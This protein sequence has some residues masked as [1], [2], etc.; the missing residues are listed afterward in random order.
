DNRCRSLNHHR[1]KLVSTNIK[2]TS[3]LNQPYLN[4]FSVSFNINKNSKKLGKMAEMAEELMSPETCAL[5]VDIRS[6]INSI[7]YLKFHNDYM[8]ALNPIDELEPLED[9]DA[10]KTF[11]EI[12][13]ITFDEMI[14]AKNAQVYWDTVVK[15]RVIDEPCNTGFVVE[16]ALVDTQYT[17]CRSMFAGLFDADDI[18][19]KFGF[20][21]EM[22]IINPYF[23]GQ[24]VSASRIENV[25]F[26]KRNVNRCRVC[27]L[28][29][30]LASAWKSCRGC[31]ARYCSDKC[32][33]FD[34]ENMR[35]YLICKSI[36]N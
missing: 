13:P 27:A 26:L 33:K 23:N 8:S 6:R 4:H 1:N 19:V 15:C 17:V 28:E 34:V 29:F 35:H 21:R 2:V 12:K 25:V 22:A 30:L 10:P 20:G 5:I 36:I 11:M 18:N 9:K 32:W 16:V 31:K 7:K 24:Y 14:T 3:Q